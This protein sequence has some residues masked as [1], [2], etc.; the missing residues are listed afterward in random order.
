MIDERVLKFDFEWR[1]GSRQRA[2]EIAREFI[3]YSRSILAPILQPLT[4]GELV[5]KVESLRA[6]GNHGDRIIVD[7]W[8]H[9]EYEPQQI[10][11]VGLVTLPVPIY[12]TN[13]DVDAGNLLKLL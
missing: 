12:K 1:E 6:E 5:A 2:V 10:T 8:I 4:I 9:S 13:A 7:M 11:G 3:D